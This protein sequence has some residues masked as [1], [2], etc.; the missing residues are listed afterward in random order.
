MIKKNRTEL[1]A[2]RI[3]T[4]LEEKEEIFLDLWYSKEVR[5]KLEQA[6]EKF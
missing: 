6:M 2:E 5:K 4:K 3:L 1:V